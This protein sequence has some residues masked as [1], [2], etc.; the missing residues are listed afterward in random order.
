MQRDDD[1]GAVPLPAVDLGHDLGSYLRG[2]HVVAAAL[3]VVLPHE[4]GAHEVLVLDVE[5]TPRPPD[6]VHVTA[7]LCLP[8]NRK[9]RKRANNPQND[10]QPE[11]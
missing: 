9:G 10:N 4:T 7:C 11:A 1:V 2:D 5:E 3:E 8:Y 6:V